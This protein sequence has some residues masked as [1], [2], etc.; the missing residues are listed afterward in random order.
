MY[1][2]YL[3]VD[4]RRHRRVNLALCV[5]LRN[6]HGGINRRLVLPLSVYKSSMNDSAQINMLEQ[7]C[8]EKHQKLSSVTSP[9]AQGMKHPSSTQIKHASLLLSIRRCV[10][11][12]HALYAT[13]IHRHSEIHSSVMRTACCLVSPCC[14][15]QPVP[16]P[17]QC[18]SQHSCTCSAHYPP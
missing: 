11:C 10:F 18:R 6:G 2:C 5:P 17:W 1:V 16:L 3:P 8:I 15:Q 12:M 13:V 14:E 4:A 9:H 7:T